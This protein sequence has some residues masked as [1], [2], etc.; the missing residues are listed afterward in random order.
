MIT[1]IT[2]AVEIDL[3]EHLKLD[4]FRHYGQIRV[5]LPHPYNQNVYLPLC[6]SRQR[7]GRRIWFLCTGCNRKTS[8]LYVWSSYD[9]ARNSIACR[10][11]LD[12]K[13]ASQYS[14]DAISK[15]DMNKRKFERLTKQKRRL[16]Y[17]GKP[18][19]FGR[20]FYKLREEQKQI[21]EQRLAETQNL[22]ARYGLF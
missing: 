7:Y 15:R 11:C 22:V 1:L 13:Y 19:Q 20:Q 18:T 10:Y 12:L 17:A 9:Y 3:Y 5:G 14:S 16:W 2:E 6:N 8:K 4:P 21:S